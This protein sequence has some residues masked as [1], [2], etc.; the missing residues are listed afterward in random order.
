[1]NLWSSS[2]RKK[3]LLADQKV[4]LFMAYYDARLHRIFQKMR[5]LQ[6]HGPIQQAP[7]VPMNPVIKPWPFR[8]KAIVLI[9]LAYQIQSQLTEGLPSFLWHTR[10][11]LKIKLLQSTP[12]YAQAN[13]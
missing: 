10:I 7:S 1:M 8:E 2:K 11:N 5:S 12:Y 4:R 6:R 13:G 3:N 9:G